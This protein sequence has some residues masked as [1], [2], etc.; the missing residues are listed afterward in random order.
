MAGSDLSRT[1][2]GPVVSLA[3]VPSPTCFLTLSLGSC[4]A[5]RLGPCRAAPSP[6][7][8]GEASPGPW[9]PPGPRER[10]HVP[11]AHA[12]LLPAGFLEETPWW[13]WTS[14]IT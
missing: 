11:S 12:G 1:V 7:A 6:V 4:Q 5:K 8:G 3:P 9:D 10:Y 13:S 14:T 2:M